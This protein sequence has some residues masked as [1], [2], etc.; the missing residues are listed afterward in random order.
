M[1]PS[2]PGRH[3]QATAMPSCIA[4]A[5]CR[6][7]QNQTDAITR[8]RGGLGGGS[9]PLTTRRNRYASRARPARRRSAPAG[10]R[11]WARTSA[12]G[13]PRPK[14]RRGR[15]APSR[16]VHPPR[17]WQPQSPHRETL[18]AGAPPACG[19]RTEEHGKSSG[20]GGGRLA[21]PLGQE[22]GHAPQAGHPATHTEGGTGGGVP[23]GPGGRRRPHPL[24]DVRGAAQLGKHAVHV[25]QRAPVV[26][27]VGPLQEAQ[28]GV[29]QRAARNAEPPSAGPVEGGGVQ[30]TDPRT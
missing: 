25:R 20:G 26:G 11:Y 19:D 15:G 17:S 12:D 1:R 18:P 24:A 13:I 30:V 2:A 5:C 27:R 4:L 16:G 14:R 9:S 6:A 22:G 29:G 7:C 28:V 8:S 3:D 23:R 10:H 21:T